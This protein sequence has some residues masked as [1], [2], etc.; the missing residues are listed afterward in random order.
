MVTQSDVAKKANV[1][2]IT[3]YR[4]L[5]NKGYVKKE[6]RAKVLK[7]VK[8]LHYYPNH[9]GRALRSKKVNTIGIVIPEP[10][11]TP[12]HGMEYYNMLMQGI[13]RFAGSHGL[14]LLLSTYKQNASGVDYYRLYFERKVDGLIL[15]IPDMRCLDVDYIVKKR[16]P[17]V[18]VGERPDNPGINYV[19]AENMEGMFGITE[20]LIR[21]GSRKIFFIKG[22]SRMRNSIDRASGFMNAMEKNGIDVRPHY[23]FNGDFT[24]DSGIGVMK[25][26]IRSGDLPDAIVC[27]NDH[28]AIGVLSEAKKANINIPSDISLAGFDDI[29]IAG[30]MDPPLTTVR[31]PLFEMGYKASE[32]LFNLIEDQ[33]RTAEKIIFPVE[34][35]IRKSILGP[36][37]D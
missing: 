9:I 15:F 12:V 37:N 21:S 6:T 25:K 27:S 32:V 35:V 5:N 8:D 31:Q 17:C 22:I 33:M 20:Y 10:P 7:A 30:L 3:V 14:D 16:I 23:L 18:I 36:D 34:L 13:D 2:F 4:V 11:N 29:N 26:I 24:I 1:S 19:D 28:M